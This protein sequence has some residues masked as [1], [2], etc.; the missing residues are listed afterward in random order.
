MVLKQNYISYENALMKLDLDS[1]DERRN[2][3]TI[4]FAKSGI[5]HNKLNDLLPKNKKLHTMQK[6]NNEK[7]KVTF[8]NT[9]RLKKSSII[10]MQTKLNEDTN[11]TTK[12][13]HG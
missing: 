9:A 6:R 2:N 8:S 10:T 4:R 3:L 7:Y 11:H 5:Q 13:N 1:L 12:R